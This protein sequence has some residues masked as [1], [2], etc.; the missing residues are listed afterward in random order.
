MTLAHGSGLTARTLTGIAF[1]LWTSA[2]AMASGA[3]DTKASTL[4]STRFQDNGD[5]TVTDRQS[6]LVW[7][8]CAAGQQWSAGQCVGRAGKVDW[9]EAQRQVE[10]VN[11][12]SDAFHGDW[13]LP[14]L[15]ELASIT[16]R[17]CGPPRTNVDVFPQTAAAAFWSSTARPGEASGE[18]VFVMSFGNAGVAPARKEERHHLRLV[19]IGP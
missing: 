2:Q 17:R 13:R 11:R 5:G 6:Q 19:R 12:D 1:A 10:R 9:Q 4:P 14:S 15:T 8:R 7:M 3:C 18:R 16:D